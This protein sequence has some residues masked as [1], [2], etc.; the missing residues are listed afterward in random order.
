MGY[1]AESCSGAHSALENEIGNFKTQSR[2]PPLFSRF[3]S[4]PWVSAF[5]TLEMKTDSLI[6]HGPKLLL[7]LFPRGMLIASWNRGG[8]SRMS[9]GRAILLVN[10]LRK[11]PV[12]DLKQSI[13]TGIW[14]VIILTH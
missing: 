7:V 13:L 5:N 14:E 11:P 1:F 9:Q 8:A 6:T 12:M 3:C 10:S 2:S 4:S